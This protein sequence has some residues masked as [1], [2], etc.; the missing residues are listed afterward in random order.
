MTYQL[1]VILVLASVGAACAVPGVFLVF[2]AIAAAVTGVA[3]YVLPGL[4]VAAQLA[5]FGVHRLHDGGE[6]HVQDRVVDTD[7]GQRQAECPQRPPPLFVGLL[8]G[9]CD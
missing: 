6:G 5:A 2:L 1:E 3:V 4:P 8:V 7:D 9:N